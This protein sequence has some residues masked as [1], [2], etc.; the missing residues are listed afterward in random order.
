MGGYIKM[1]KKYLILI[2][3]IPLF[4]GFASQSLAAGEEELPRPTDV[5]PIYL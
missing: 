4:F 1:K 3:A 5:K 2:I